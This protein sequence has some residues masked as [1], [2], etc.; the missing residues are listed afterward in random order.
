MASIL[1]GGECLDQPG[2]AAPLAFLFKLLNYQPEPW[3]PIDT[4]VIQGVMTQDL[5]FSTT[6][7]DYAQMVRA[8]GYDRTMQ[9]FPVLRRV[10]L[11]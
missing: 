1:Q 6:P 8:P 11:R 10:S 7:L 4:L 5:D 2:R 3:T 9:W